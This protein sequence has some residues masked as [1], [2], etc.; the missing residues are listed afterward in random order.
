MKE[1]ILIVHG[2]SRNG[3]DVAQKARELLPQRNVT[4][5]E[6]LIVNK[7]KD[8]LKAVRRAVKSGARLIAV[9]GG[10]GAMTTAVR[11]LAYTKATLAVLPAGT[12]NSFALSLGIHSLDEALESIVSGR[13]LRVDLG[14]ANGTYFANFAS[15]GLASV[16]AE[17]TPRGLKKLFGPLAYGLAGIAALRLHRP[18]CMRVE[19]KKNRLVFDAHQALIASGRYYAHEPLLPQAQIDDGLLA[20]FATAAKDQLD[21]VRTNAALLR[22]DQTSLPNAQYF[23]AP[24]ITITCK[25]RQA[26]AVDGSELGKT[27]VKFQVA[28]KALRVLVPQ[29]AGD[30]E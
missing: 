17:A 2:N 4:I 14:I 15:I 11:A 13:E 20:F 24:K 16:A 8:L 26:V 6:S 30:D 18:F 25:P 23:Q 28:R 12:G 3:V 9:A 27:P 5:A 19:W 1:A 7:S 29:A 21:I 22:G 10:D